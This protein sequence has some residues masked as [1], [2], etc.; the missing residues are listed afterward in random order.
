MLKDS[1]ILGDGKIIK[2]D[3][4]DLEISKEVFDKSNCDWS[5]GRRGNI[6]PCGV[7]CMLETELKHSCPNELCK[8]KLFVWS[9]S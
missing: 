4:C 7:I 8:A 1:A 5:W 3:F 9:R 2:C 6:F